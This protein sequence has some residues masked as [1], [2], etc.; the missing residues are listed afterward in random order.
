MYVKRKEVG[1]KGAKAV[2]GEE[3]VAGRTGQSA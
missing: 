1:G 3:K 2:V